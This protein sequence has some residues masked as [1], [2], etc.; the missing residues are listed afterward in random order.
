M[1]RICLLFLFVFAATFANAQTDRI[2]RLSHGG[3]ANG[4]IEEPNHTLGIP[5][6]SIV[7]SIDSIVFLS[8]TSCIQYTNLGQTA[9]FKHPLANDPK[10]SFDSLQKLYPK[11]K[12]IGFEKKTYQ[13]MLLKPSKAA[14]STSGNS[15]WLLGG[16]TLLVVSL[17]FMFIRI[18]KRSRLT[19]LTFAGLLIVN[20]AW[21]QTERIARLSHGGSAQ[22]SHSSHSLGGPAI[23]IHIDS[24]VF[25]NDTTVIQYTNIFSPS[26]IHHPIAN[27][28]KV[29]L[30]SLQKLYPDTKLIGF[31]KK[32]YKAGQLKMDVSH[33]QS[34][35]GY[36]FVF[37]GIV[38]AVLLYRRLR[39]H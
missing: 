17:L 8:D 37:A 34:G 11:T 1:Q 26:K 39:T 10:V 12:L 35:F 24:I 15:I 33:P 19:L 32:S 20:L 27:D 9:P 5:S 2:S 22:T 38:T 18:N 6:K 13:A 3:K 23:M 16:I 4:S 31:D 29:S 28:P 7:F 25:I 21:S 30:D 14:S 36:L